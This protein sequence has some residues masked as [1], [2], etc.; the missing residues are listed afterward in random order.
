METQRLISIAYEVCN[1]QSLYTIP[2]HNKTLKQKFTATWGTQ[3]ELIDKNVKLT[4]SLQII[5][6]N[7]F[8]DF[9]KKWSGVLCKCYLCRY[10]NLNCTAISNFTILVSGDLLS[11]EGY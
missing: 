6:L 8:I 3:M 10:L 1:R 11:A 2:K 9:M 5:Q 7:N 4:L